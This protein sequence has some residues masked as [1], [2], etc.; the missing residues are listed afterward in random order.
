M[1]VE[2]NCTDQVDILSRQAT[3]ATP[4]D[5]EGESKHGINQKVEEKLP[6]RDVP[7]ATGKVEKEDLTPENMVA[8]VCGMFKNARQMDE[9]E[10]FESEEAKFY[11]DLFGIDF[12]TRALLHELEYGRGIQGRRV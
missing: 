1:V 5:T 12:E 2:M 10:W 6:V 4:S 8:L 9:M 11:L 7:D 3:P